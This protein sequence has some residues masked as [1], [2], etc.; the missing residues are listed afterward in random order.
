MNDWF[1]KN[2]TIEDTKKR[3]VSYSQYK[4]YST[5]PKQ[6]RLQ[7]VDFKQPF[8]DSID[9]VFGTAIHETIQEWLIQH[10]AD[11]KRAKRIDLDV[12]FKEHLLAEFKSRTNPNKSGV[13]RFVCN[14]ETL[15]G[16]YND[17]RAILTHLQKYA[18]DFFPTKGYK[19]L[20]CEIPLIVP[21]NENLQFKAYLDI[22]IA[23]TRKNQ[24]H[25]ID[26]KT[27][28]RGW[29][30][31]QKKDSQKINQILLYKKF[32]SQKFNVGL[33]NIFPRFIILKRKITENQDFA[34]KRLSNF[35]PS[36]GKISLGK[37]EKEWKTFIKECF[38]ET[39]MLRNRDFKATP[40]EH[41][42]KFCPFREKGCTE[43]WYTRIK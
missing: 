25:I 32:Y 20:G 12:P 7:Y 16:Y 10:F 22:V 41:N 33:D 21:L 4:I 23:D 24:I 8:T 36:H 18:S 39:G 26:L 31:Y 38:D 43:S 27:S 30:S 14:K 35:E 5:C 9:T 37:A 13:A 15:W 17:G 34:I 28:G 40:S 3:T 1:E 6:W 29:N 11:E 19:L 42:C 2:E